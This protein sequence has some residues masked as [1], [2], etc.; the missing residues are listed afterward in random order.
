MF[1][2]CKNTSNTS[3]GDNH[4]ALN[5]KANNATVKRK[6]MTSNGDKTLHRKLKN[7]QHEPHEKP[8]VITGAP[9]W[10]ADLAP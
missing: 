3:K 6:K 1:L 8:G 2:S 7:Q 5:R 9:V 4:K 10:Q